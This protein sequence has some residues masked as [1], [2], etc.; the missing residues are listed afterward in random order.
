MTVVAKNENLFPLSTISRSYTHTHI[1]QFLTSIMSSVKSLAGLDPLKDLL[2]D[3]LTRL[4]ALESKVGGGAPIV[5]SP[6]ASM[7]HGG[8]SIS[9]RLYALPSLA[10]FFVTLRRIIVRSQ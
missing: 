8:T 3:V 2:G 9:M 7:P 5:P 6:P 1:S 10:P 4:E